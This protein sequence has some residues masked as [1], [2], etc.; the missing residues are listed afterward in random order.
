MQYLIYGCSLISIDIDIIVNTEE[1]GEKLWVVLNINVFLIEPIFLI[2][3]FYK[4]FNKTGWTDQTDRI[5]GGLINS[6]LKTLIL[7]KKKALSTLLS[8]N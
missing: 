1:G 3:Y 2:F 8:T 4:F 5:V 7:K 6:I